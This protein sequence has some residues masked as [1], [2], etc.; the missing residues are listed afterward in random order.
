MSLYETLKHQLVQLSDDTATLLDDAEKITET[1]DEGLSRWKITCRTIARQ[2]HEE[3]MRVAVVGAIKSGKSTLVNT[4]FGGD[5][6]KR[7]AGVVTSIVTRV[8]CSEKLR[9]TLFLKNWAAVNEDIGQAS[10]LLPA[11]HRADEGSAGFDLRREPDRRILE[12]ALSELAADQLITNDTRSAGSVL[13]SS[14]LTGF[15]RVQPYIGDDDSNAVF[16]N[17]RFSQHRDFVGDDTM[18]VYLKDVLLEIDRPGPGEGVEIADCQGS[19]SPNPLHMA[20]IQDYLSMAHLTV[21]AISSR[22]GVRQADIRFL[23]MI[24]NMGIMDSVVFVVNCDL[25]EHES[26]DSLHESLKRIQADL[27]LICPEPEIFSFSSL[28]LLMDQIED[29]LSPRDRDR[30][31]HWRRETAMVDFC[32]AEWARFQAFL[33][34]KIRRERSALLLK[35]HLERLEIVSSGISNWI[36]FQHAL[37][38]RDSGGAKALADRLHDQRG[39]LDR[40]KLTV[41][42]TLDGAVHQVKNDMKRAVDQFFDAHGDGA[43]ARLIHF[44]HGYP[45]EMQRYADS[46]QSAGFARTLYLVFQEFKQVVDRHMAES[47]NPEVIRFLQSQERYLVDYLDDIAGPYGSMIDDALARYAGALDD[48]KMTRREDAPALRIG[49]E[50][51]AIRK[52]AALSRPTAAATMHYSAQIKTEAVMRLGFYKLVNLVRQAFKRPAEKARQEPFLAMDAAVKRMKRET[53]RSILFHLKDHKENIKFQYLLKLADAAAAALQRQM[54]ERFQ[55]HGAD[56]SQLVQRIGETQLDKEKI[57]A[58]LEQMEATAGS[59]KTRISDIKAKLQQL[60]A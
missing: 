34:H 40:L 14:Y 23:S 30:L 8:R 59:V 38:T 19:D 42:N 10:L 27:S 16:E 12:R 35:N 11:Q 33:D 3:T 44:V 58:S 28:F 43:V 50:M 21:Y 47:V 57:T 52:M 49:S 17:G 24:R 4:L 2:M 48:V 26:L 36:G 60:S 32:S 55:H 51:E 54:L 7:G 13:L 56:L 29:Q 53:E 41:K 45:V 1:G 25:S 39:R 22:T 18:A 6:L 20:M 9:A 5:F 46:L 37:L 31:S 15:D